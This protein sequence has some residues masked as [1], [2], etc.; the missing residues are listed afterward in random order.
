LLCSSYGIVVALV[1]EKWAPA[2]AFVWIL[3]AALFG[4]M[5]SWLVSFAAH[6]V[7]RKRLSAEEIA[8][9]PLHARLGAA[10][11]ALGFILVVAAILHTWWSSRVSMISGTTYLVGLSVA[12]HVI[13]AAKRP[14]AQ[15]PNALTTAAAPLPN[16]PDSTMTT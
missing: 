14:A 12:Y 13:R 7:F 5:L 1:L 3:G 15:S 11:S 8:E 4:L 16:S 9:L 2:N 10:G 6:V